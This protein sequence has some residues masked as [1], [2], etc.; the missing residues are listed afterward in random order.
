MLKRKL[1]FYRWASLAGR[2][3]FDPPAVA[4]RLTQEISAD[5]S[6]Q[7]V[8]KD[9]VITAV[10]VVEP[11]GGG[12]PVK[13][14]VLALRGME[15]RPFKWDPDSSI[16]PISLLA[17]EYPADAT[18]ISI[19]PDGYC[20]HDMGRYSP[21]LSR[22]AFFLRQR[23]REYVS[24][25]PLY[26]EDAFRKLKEMEGQFRSFDLAMT[27]PEYATRPR[28]TF[29]HLWPAVAGEELPSV[30]VSMGMGR[31]GPKDKY[32]DQHIEDELLEL[33]T[34]ASDLL[35]GMV[36]RGRSK[37]TNRVEMVNLLTDR[38]NVEVDLPQRSD[39]PS[40]PQVSSVF[41]ELEQAYK[42]FKR[43]DVFETVSTAELMRKG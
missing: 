14:R 7:M 32:I 29:G 19:W 4:R 17:N 31:Y 12:D 35:T 33:A 43:R 3:P 36:V 38:L 23:M 24:F 27:K 6:C 42:D 34:Q 25:D 9:G 5:S 20:A 37:R 26:D 30:R 2:D 40:A 21:R 15:D 11:G 1:V 18:H 8:D 39:I 41:Y 10:E 28:G 22:L 13:F 16:G